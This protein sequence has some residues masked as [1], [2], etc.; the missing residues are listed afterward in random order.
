MLDTVSPVRFTETGKK[1]LGL[2]LKRYRESLKL[3]LRGAENYIREMGG[4]L[5]F[6]TISSIEKGHREIETANLLMLSQIGYGGMTFT[7]MVD[8]LTENRLSLCEKPVPYCVNKEAKEA[9]AV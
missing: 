1:T 6:N 9:I 8:I 4:D 5:S 7:Q 3:S 2:K